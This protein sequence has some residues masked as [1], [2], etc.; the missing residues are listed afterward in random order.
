MNMGNKNHRMKRT[1]SRSALFIVTI[2]LLVSA[3]G[4]Y[5]QGGTPGG[6]GGTPQVT[7][8]QSETGTP[9][10][11][12]SVTMADNGSTIHL[13][14]GERFLL[15]LGNQYDWTVVV[16]NPAIVSRVVNITVIKGA[17]GVYQANEVGTTTLSAVAGTT[18]VQESDH[19]CETQPPEFDLQIIVQ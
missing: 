10:G 13:K 8:T 1:V 18:C 5:G 9:S 4:S 12:L 2:A 14:V 19:P 15:D 11:E 6:Y 7:A 3:C 16:D 17:Q